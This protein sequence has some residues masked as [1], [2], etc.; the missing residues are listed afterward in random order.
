MSIELDDIGSGFSRGKINLNF[1]R[2]EDYINDNLLHRDGVETGQANQMEND[3]D[4]N[5]YA[6]LNVSVDVEDPS[7]LLTVGDGDSRYINTTGDSMTG[8][9]S[10]LQ[11]TQNSHPIRRD[12]F[13]TEHNERVSRENEIEDNYQASD[14][15]LQAQITE[16]S[17]IAAAE[18]PAIQWHSQIIE[19]S[20]VIP[21]NVNAF[22][23]GPV[24]TLAD[25]VSITLGDNS[26][27]TLL[28][29]V[30]YA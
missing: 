9:L 23:A 4:L 11:P 5:G 29:G 14:A 28:D 17:P 13:D 27:Y 19:N 3:L 25:G 26:V 21:D 20:M 6:L 8:G 12:Q 10:V 30:E 22:S 1:Q 16:A 7:S 18:R 15:S 24:M 2:I